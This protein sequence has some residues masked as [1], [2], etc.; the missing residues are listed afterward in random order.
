MDHHAK[1]PGR[2]PLGPGELAPDK[3]K[4]LWRLIKHNE[5][6]TSNDRRWLCICQC[7]STKWVKEQALKHNQS[8]S[9]GCTRVKVPAASLSQ[10]S[11]WR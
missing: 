2:P 3:L 9:C 7:G 4:G 1:K 5:A 11:G 10:P 8:R 6:R